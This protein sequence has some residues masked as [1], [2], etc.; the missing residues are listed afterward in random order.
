VTTNLNQT[1]SVECFE[2]DAFRARCTD[3]LTC[4][5][6][7]RAQDNI[8]VAIALLLLVVL[9]TWLCELVHSC[10]LVMHSWQTSAHYRQLR[11][12]PRK[13]WLC[14]T[15]NMPLLTQTLWIAQFLV[16]LYVTIV[17][18][19][20]HPVC[21]G[22]VT[23]SGSRYQFWETLT[24]YL[25]FV[26]GI[27]LIALGLGTVV[28][29]RVRL[30]GELY[31]PSFDDS[32][33]VAEWVDCSEIRRRPPPKCCPD[34]QRTIRRTCCRACYRAG[35]VYGACLDVLCLPC[36]KA[37]EFCGWMYKHRHFCGP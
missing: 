18:Y 17:S 3:E 4:E 6:G 14:V 36:L 29:H 37:G 19:V 11:D 32:V 1:V 16:L 15:K 7:Q 21:R 23:A 9:A 13:T 30:R 22:A 35:H 24:A 20:V 5:S 27:S 26:G 12:L 28:R 10:G 25:T 33:R 34:M 31:L 8:R 2:K